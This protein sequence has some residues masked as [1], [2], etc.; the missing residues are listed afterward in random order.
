MSSE[1]ASEVWDYSL[2]TVRKYCQ[3]GKIRGAFEDERDC[4]RIP[5]Y[6]YPP[7]VPVP[8]EKLTQRHRREIARCAHEG[9]NPHPASTLP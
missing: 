4:W 9:E 7:I 1:R 5:D 3:E 6:T 8:G 2:N